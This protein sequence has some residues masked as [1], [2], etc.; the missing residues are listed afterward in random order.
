MALHHVHRRP[1]TSP[2][3]RRLRRRVRYHGP[4]TAYCLITATL[5]AYVLVLMHQAAG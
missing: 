5:M 4:F 1:V 3:V 2:A